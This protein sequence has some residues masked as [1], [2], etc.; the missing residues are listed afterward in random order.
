MIM[1]RT[2]LALV[3]LSL[4]AVLP[5][6]SDDPAYQY[7]KVPT[8]KE[9]SIPLGT[10]YPLKID[11]AVPSEGTT[12]VDITNGYTDNITIDPA[13]LVLK[14]RPAVQR[15]TVSL[16]GDKPT[17][18]ASPYVPITFKIRDTSESLTMRFKVEGTVT[19]DYGLPPD[20]GSDPDFGVKDTG[21]TAD[22]GTMVDAGPVVDQATSD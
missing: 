21:T 8:V 17:P 15:Q 11:L 5:Q 1:K 19:Y 3:G 9:I 16:R 4:L 2:L 7:I 20:Y 6:C 12:Y 13:S 18:K 14:Y 22:K 10:T